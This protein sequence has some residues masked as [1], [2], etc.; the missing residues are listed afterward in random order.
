MYEESVKIAMIDDHILIRDALA[1][2]IA[3]FEKC[4]VVLLAQHGKEFIE[5]LQPD[6]L[7]Q[8]AILDLNMPTLN[9]YETS[10]WLKKHYPQ[11]RVLILSMHDSE[12]ALIQLLQVGVRGFVRKDMHPHELKEAIHS[13]MD[14]GYYYS[15]NST[16]KALI[17]FTKQAGK[18][19]IRLSPALTN[20]ELTFLRLVSTDLTYKEIAVKMNISP[21]TVDNYRDSL[22]LKLNVS[23]RIGLAIFA[24]QSG[25]AYINSN[26]A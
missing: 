15:F 18:N 19:R 8:L 17:Q 9:G 25:L 5:K 16:G 13:V 7:P 22:F 11:I 26:Q 10:K 1:G 4:R 3:G 24:L 23:S 6:N 14:S 12:I 2:T 21:R 20:N